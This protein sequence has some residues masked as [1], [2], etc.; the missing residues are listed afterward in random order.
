[1]LLLFFVFADDD[2][3]VEVQTSSASRRLLWKV[4]KRDSTA[5]SPPL[6]LDNLNAAESIQTLINYFR[7][8]F[9]STLIN[10]I[11]EQSNLYAAQVNF[12]SPL[13]LSCDEFDKFLAV[14]LLM[15][16]VALPRSRLYWSINLAV[17]QLKNTL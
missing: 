6:W 11:V 3:N 5:R 15:S 13:Q 7:N 8:F 14:V 17:C 16:F 2:H 9:D 10:H 4:I 12:A 1:M